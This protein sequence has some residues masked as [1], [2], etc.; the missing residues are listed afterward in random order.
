[1]LQHGGVALQANNS[2]LIS[3]CILK[4]LPQQKNPRVLC[5]WGNSPNFICSHIPM[6]IFLFY[7]TG[8][9]LVNKK[10]VAYE[11]ERFQY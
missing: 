3:M 6:E 8:K 4:D 2:L 7:E 5:N 10:R 9:K 1:M 11:G